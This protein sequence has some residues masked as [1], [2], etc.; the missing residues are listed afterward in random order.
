MPLLTSI[1]S[2]VRGLPAAVAAGQQAFT[3][4]GTHSFVVP[5]GVTSISAVCV[6]AGA[7]G[8]RQFDNGDGYF[9][10]QGGGG[11]GLSYSNN[12]TVTPGE[13]LTVV[14][15][16]GGAGTSG[17]AGGDSRIHRSGTNL[18]LAKGG[19]NP[20]GGALASGV[21]DVRRSG[22]NGNYHDEG[23]GLSGATGGGAAGYTA[24]GGTST[25]FNNRGG[26]GVSLNGGTSG[27]SGGG[28]GSAA[29]TVYGGGGA[30]LGSGAQGGVRIIW[31]VGRAYPNTNTADI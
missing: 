4:V 13:T 24:N 15:G 27:G 7:G 1:R 20:N 12:I 5:N 10:Y 9:L 28:S 21:G 25:G 17:G 23:E 2:L 22:G 16:S 14:V 6:G 26:T 19:T 8:W 31:G 29:G 30:P 11:G 3:T 18:V